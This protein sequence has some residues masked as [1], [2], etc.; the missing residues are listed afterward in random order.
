MVGTAQDAAGDCPALGPDFLWG[1]EGG[2]WLITT[3]DSTYRID[4]DAM[5]IDRF[6]FSNSTS[7]STANGPTRP[8]REIVECRVGKHGY[9]LLNPEGRDVETV[10]YFWQR[11]SPV[12]RIDPAPAQRAHRPEQ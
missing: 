8:L 5:T 9:W 12:L 10:E 6:R 1:I 7:V 4:L 2:C 3:D 11:S